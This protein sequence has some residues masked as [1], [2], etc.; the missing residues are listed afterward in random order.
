MAK[1][2]DLFGFIAVARNIEREKVDKP[3]QR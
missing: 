2:G 1:N 3:K